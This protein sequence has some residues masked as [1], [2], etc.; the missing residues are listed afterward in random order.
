[1]PVATLT[2]N[3]PEEQHS[4]NNAVHADDMSSALWDI[5]IAVRAVFKHGD[6]TKDRL[7]KTLEEIRNIASEFEPK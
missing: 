4:F 5:Q 1:M 7:V 2:F 6:V 3:L